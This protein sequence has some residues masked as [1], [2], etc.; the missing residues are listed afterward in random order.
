MP[1]YAKTQENPLIKVTPAQDR[2]SYDDA[3]R[4]AIGT[5]SSEEWEARARAAARKFW[6]DENLPPRER[7]MA[8]ARAF[9]RGG[10][11]GGGFRSRTPGEDDE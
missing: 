7:C 10:A 3:L 5:D 2:A 11:I 1:K 6:V 9:T 8:I 4:R